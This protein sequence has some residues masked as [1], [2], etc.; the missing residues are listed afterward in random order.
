M[1]NEETL[2]KS[3]RG[4][5]REAGIR[6]G[7]ERAAAEFA[8]DRKTLAKRL[9]AMGEHG[10]AGP[11][12]CFSTLQIC[13]AVYGDLQRAKIRRAQADA[14]LSELDLKQKS[15]LVVLTSDVVSAWSKITQAVRLRISETSLSDD[16][17]Q[18]I[19]ADLREL[20]TRDY[21]PDV[22]QE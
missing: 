15:A 11:D 17:K 21:A 16:E 18:V 3:N 12:T 9:V 6:W 10:M 22:E 13:A 8:I 5:K 4:Q 1:T 20:S 7:I 2:T 19:L 14:E